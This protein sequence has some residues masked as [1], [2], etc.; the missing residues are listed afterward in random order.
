ML[1]SLSSRDPKENRLKIKLKVYQ[2]LD[3]G[4]LIWGFCPVFGLVISAF[5]FSVGLC[6]AREKNKQQQYGD[7]SEATHEADSL[8]TRSKVGVGSFVVKSWKL[9]L[10]GPG[11]PW[12]SMPK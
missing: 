4:F 1:H 8:L 3:L 6:G 7:K 5:A 2:R 10:S 12:C 11:C 9:L